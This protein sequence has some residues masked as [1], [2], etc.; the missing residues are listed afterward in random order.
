MSSCI[1]IDNSDHNYYTHSISHKHKFYSTVATLFF[2]TSFFNKQHQLFMSSPPNQT[3]W[4]RSI[5]MW[6]WNNTLSNNKTRRIRY[7]SRTAYRMV[8]TC[9]TRGW[10]QSNEPTKKDSTNWKGEGRLS[11]NGCITDKAQLQ[12]LK[13]KHKHASQLLLMTFKQRR[14]CNICNQ[15]SI[16]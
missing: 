4:S 16:F 15:R 8:D 3:G 6:V 14:C 2:L 12:F 7:N 9:T 1:T 13:P 10:K 5:V 11:W